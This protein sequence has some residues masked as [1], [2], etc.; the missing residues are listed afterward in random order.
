MTPADRDRISLGKMAGSWTV[1]GWS[2]VSAGN[3]ET[4]SGSAT[5]V[6]EQQFFL[7]LD[8]SATVSDSCQ[9]SSGTLTFASE[10]GRGVTLHSRFDD[11]PSMARFAGMGNPDSTLLT[12]DETD[13]N[14]PGVR[15]RV[16]IRFLTPDQ[17]LADVQNLSQP[18]NPLIGSFS[19]ARAR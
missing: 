18:S 8:M 15:R 13:T 19:F 6:I 16:V 1:V 4:I 2:E 17:W 11:S 9:R 3:R 14:T 12:L 5:G 10:P 7:R